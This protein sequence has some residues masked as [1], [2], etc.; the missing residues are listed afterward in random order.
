M[1]RI[2][3]ADDDADMRALASQLLQRRGFEV[4]TAGDGSEAIEL[5]THAG[6]DLV[7]TDMNMPGRDGHEVCIAVRRHPSLR[8]IPVVLLTALPLDD[9]R[10]LQVSADS[11]AIVVAKTDITRLADLADQLVTSAA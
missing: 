1:A 11:Q 9:R 5:I 7:I 6:L 2:L 8:G 3:F 4:V 10:V